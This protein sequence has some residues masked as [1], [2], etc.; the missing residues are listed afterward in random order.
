MGCL[1]EGK[2]ISMTVLVTLPMESRVSPILP[3]PNNVGGDGE[4][5]HSTGSTVC[6]GDDSE[7]DDHDQVVFNS[8]S[9]EDYA[10]RVSQERLLLKDPLERYRIH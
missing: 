7:K 8:F 6:E 10:C 3:K 9:F 5:D 2:N 4:I 1:G